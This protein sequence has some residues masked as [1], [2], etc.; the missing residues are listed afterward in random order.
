MPC[1]RWHASMRSHLPS[2][3]TQHGASADS[4]ASMAAKIGHFHTL[5]NS[6]AE[7]EAECAE[8]ERAEA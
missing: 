2:V 7:A 8:A 1:E 6:A 4:A 3:H 5:R